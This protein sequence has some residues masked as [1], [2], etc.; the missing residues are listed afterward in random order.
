LLHGPEQSSLPYRQFNDP[1]SLNVEVYLSFKKQSMVI[2]PFCFQAARSGYS[3]A[4]NGVTLY[5]EAPCFMPIRPASTQRATHAAPSTG[6]AMFRFFP[7]AAWT[8]L[9]AANLC[10]QGLPPAV[11]NRNPVHDLGRSASLPQHL[12][13]PAHRG[14]DVLKESLVPG[15]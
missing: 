8:S 15:T 7:A 3:Q 4:I 1:V 12:G 10:G 5:V 2:E 6:V 13:H 9:I 14:I 11:L